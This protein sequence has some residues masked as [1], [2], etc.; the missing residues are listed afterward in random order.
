VGLLLL[1]AGLIL[2]IAGGTWFTGA[3]TVGLILAI[4]GGLMF[5]AQ[6]VVQLLA[7]RTINK[8]R[9]DMQIGRRRL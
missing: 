1:V 5:L 4:V 6:V 7:A 9:K 8:V 3:A 2:L